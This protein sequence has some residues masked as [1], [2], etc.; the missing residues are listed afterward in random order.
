MFLLPAPTKPKF[1]DRLIT[2]SG[3]SKKCTGG[4]VKKRGRRLLVNQDSSLD[5]SDQSEDEEAELV[6]SVGSDEEGATRYLQLQQGSDDTGVFCGY[7]HGLTATESEPCSPVLDR[8]CCATHAGKERDARSPPLSPILPGLVKRR[9]ESF[10]QFQENVTRRAVRPK[11]EERARSEKR[12]SSD[13]PRARRCFSPVT[14]KADRLVKSFYSLSRDKNF[15][16]AVM[17]KGYVR[18]L[19]E[20]INTGV[21]QTQEDEEDEG[22]GDGDG[23]AEPRD[24]SPGG[25]ISE[26]GSVSPAHLCHDL[27]GGFHR[28]HEA[29]EEE[30]KCQCRTIESHSTG[31]QNSSNGEVLSQSPSPSDAG[32]HKL[33][34]SQSNTQASKEKQVWSPRTRRKGS[35][36]PLSSHNP[37]APTSSP[38]GMQR[39]GS[40]GSFQSSGQ[41]SGPGLESPRRIQK[42]QNKPPV[43]YT[44]K[45]KLGTQKASL[46]SSVNGES[47]APKKCSRNSNMDGSSAKKL[48]Q[49]RSRSSSRDKSSVAQSVSSMESECVEDVA[50]SYA[51]CDNVFF[52]DPPMSPEEL[53]NNSWSSDCD[54]EEFTDSEV[55]ENSTTDKQVSVASICHCVNVYVLFTCNLHVVS[56]IIMI[57]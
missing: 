25:D 45:P 41:C 1:L 39:Q 16:K 36:S 40:S 5:R 12:G 22:S 11:F 53:F 20:Q 6:T 43:D 49:C 3:L 42:L 18:A 35:E 17:E 57:P 46:S 9:C 31:P 44:L 37:D 51:A 56:P 34:K 27:E 55:E 33:S 52:G 8:D 24:R 54:S 21:L 23:A 15:S 7:S 4:R 47:T 19:A 50:N 26:E 28:G 30:I 38:A 29:K 48:S 13:S 14:E 32:D 10:R 2:S